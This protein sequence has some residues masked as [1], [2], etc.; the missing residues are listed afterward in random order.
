[1]TFE[2]FLK[3]ISFQKLTFHCTHM[4]ADW[5]ESASAFSIFLEKEISYI[6]SGDQFHELFSANTT[7]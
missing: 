6:T 1:L 2:Y 3:D 4:F 7:E 5:L